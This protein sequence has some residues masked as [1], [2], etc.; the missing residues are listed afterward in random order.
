M[1]TSQV[2]NPQNHNGKELHYG[3]LEVGE[4]TFSLGG[5]ESCWMSGLGLNVNVEL[6]GEEVICINKNILDL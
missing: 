2:R 3:S 1:D 6:S 4:T 5:N